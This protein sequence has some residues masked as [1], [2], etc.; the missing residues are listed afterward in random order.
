MSERQSIALMQ[1][2]SMRTRWVS[3]CVM[4][5]FSII[6]VKGAIMALA[7]FEM[8]HGV[9][10]AF[11]APRHRADIIDRNG[12]LLATS[13]T[14]YSVFADAR[15]IGDANLVLQELMQVLP[16][17]DLARLQTAL[18]NS[19]R[20]FVWIERGL[21]PRQKQMV[22][23]LGLE[24][25]GFRRDSRRAYPRGVLAGHVLGYAGDDGQGLGGLEYALDS[26]LLDS[27]QPVQLTLDANVQFSLEVE[28]SAAVGE[29]NAEAGAG[30]VLNARNGEILAMA[31]W[32]PLDPHRAT[33]LQPDDPALLNRASD[34][35]YELGSVYKPLTIAAALDA[36]AIHPE[37]R[38]D[39]RQPVLIQGHK[40]QDDH[41][42]NG[43]ATPLEIISESSNIGTVKVAWQLGARRQQAFLD[44]LG[45]LSRAPIELAGSTFP[46]LPDAFDDITSAT[47]SYGHGISVSP[48]S[49]A[50]AFSALANNGEIAQ[51]TLLKS[52]DRQI[53]QRRVMAAPTAAL[54]TQ[55]M[56]QAV[57]VGTG[58]RADVPG[59][60]VAGKTGTAEKIVLRRY[61]E[62]ENICSFAAIF[63]SDSPEYVVLVMLDTP[64]AGANRG[65]AAGWNAAP[66]A[67]RVI[68]RIAPILGVQPKFDTENGT[69]HI[70]AVSH[71]EGT[72]L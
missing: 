11:Q 22:F 1:G 32:P 29:Y 38:F 30:I 59:Y 16:D 58:R 70:R 8:R 62:T 48:I 25:I 47:A 31:S 46:I 6:V 5:L 19:E 37:D 68:E 51:P 17:L 20:A 52:P 40:I 33:K 24:G 4:A 41:P 57:K 28:L 15:A 61:S 12:D 45:L 21:T 7:P 18:S 35:P 49:F 69:P 39:V 67:G 26:R 44:A 65:R 13:V 56:R 43:L 53:S 42:I 60:R 64:K 3:L 63:P 36:G 66:T 34:A 72:S 10:A 14:A 54:V 23:D 50:I 55:M 2:A 71:R 27:E 9:S